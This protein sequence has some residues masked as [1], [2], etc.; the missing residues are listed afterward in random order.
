MKLLSSLKDAPEL[1]GGFDDV[2]SQ[3]V[4]GTI[5]SELGFSGNVERPRYALRDYIDY[6]AW[7]ISHVFLR[8]MA[9]G[10]STFLLVFGGWVVTV[11]AAFNTV[12]GD[13]LYPVKLA[14][15]RVQL[16]LANNEQRT[17]LHAE[18]ASRR[19]EEVLEISSSSRDGK[20]VRVREA[21]ENFKAEMTSASAELENM[22]LT[23]PETVAEVA[24]DVN[25]RVDEYVAV[26]EQTQAEP[27]LDQGQQDQVG[28]AITAVEQADQ[29][30]TEV[31][32]ASHEATQEQKT[33]RYLQTAFQADL[34]DIQDRRTLAL[35]RMDAVAT[36][37]RSVV[38]PNEEEDLTTIDAL[39]DQ[40]KGFDAQISEAMNLFA[41]GGFRR[42]LEI[43]N[44]LKG[45]LAKAEDALAIM[46]INI[47]TAQTTAAQGTSGRV[48][49][50]VSEIQPETPCRVSSLCPDIKV[51]PALGGSPDATIQ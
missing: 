29:Q 10:V 20:D 25:R 21:V 43:V 31:I 45:E 14:T 39:R 12:P 22:T 27:A 42:V 16:S 28:E 47:T 8:P 7:R 49:D 5:S 30:V 26:L 36:A 11:N 51:D 50:S 19:L 33:A 44:A 23:S 34:L 4:W 2:A 15:E 18:F 6:V 46:E 24:I 9:V 38:M 40:L 3:R 35:G 32:I 13:F 48:S 37:L 41:A 17:R 1:G